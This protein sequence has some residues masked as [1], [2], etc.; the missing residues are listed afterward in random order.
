MFKSL[1]FLIT[2]ISWYVNADNIRVVTEHLP[3][4]Q[5]VENRRIVDGS[6]YLI[7]KE[8]LKRA[9]IQATHEVMP[10]ARAYKVALST[11]NTI[12]YSLT[13]SPER[14]SLFKW[15]GQLHHLEYSFFSAKS[16]QKV[17]IKTASD[18]LNYTVVSVRDS[19][20]ANSLQRMGFK[21]G[22]NLE[23]VVDYTTAWKMLQ[24]G[25]VELIY[26]SAP[27]ILGPNVN[28][29]LFKKQGNV[30]EA[31]ELYV[32]ANLN[33]DDQVLDNL[34]TALQS[35]KKDPLLKALFN[36]HEVK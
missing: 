11:D 16:N 26:D 19:F 17:N 34:S 18:A 30:V 4:Y 24:M 27:I 36:I 29:S 20:E 1:L 28:E 35:V 8:V 5:I 3:P 22:V 7:M 25:R 12:I 6:S 33:T 23:L 31:F 10:W 14:E 21:L 15:I 13:R 9:K 2:L 32:A